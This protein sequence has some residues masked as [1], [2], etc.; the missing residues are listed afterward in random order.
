MVVFVDD[1]L[2][3]SVAEADLT[4]LM[5]SLKA[6]FAEV[7]GCG[8]DDFSDLGM[9]VHNNRG[10]Q[11]IEVSMEGYE[12]E[13][14]R[15]SGITVVRSTP[16][17]SNL[18]EPGV[19]EKLGPAELANFHTLVA[20]LLYLNCRTRPQIATAVSYLTTRV[21]CANKGDVKK[22]NR[23]IMFING[24]R[25][26][27]LYFRFV[28]VGFGSHDDGKSQTGVIHKLR[29]STVSAKSQKQKMV[30]K[31]STEGE[32]VGLTDR[33]DGEFMCMQGHDMDDERPERGVWPLRMRMSEVYF[34]STLKSF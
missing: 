29:G 1:I 31:D 16:A 32:L 6:K 24:S 15:Y 21:T 10:E 34:L 12:D 19:T 9:H 33:V 3:T 18:F 23:V 14:M 28:D 27:K 26:N 8:R 30:A 5:G 7:K 4:W 17:S 2:A 11:Q 25:D 22:L 13:L 20:K